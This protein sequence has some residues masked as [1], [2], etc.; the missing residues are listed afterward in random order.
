VYPKISP[1]PIIAELGDQNLAPLFNRISITSI[2]YANA[3]LRF[4]EYF[5]WK[6][7]N[8]MIHPL[9]DYIDL[10]TKFYEFG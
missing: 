9:T 10:E 7:C 2:E 1:S 3:Y 6:S 8:W 4:F 5:G